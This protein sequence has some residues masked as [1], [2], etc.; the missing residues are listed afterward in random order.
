ML[1]DVRIKVKDGGLGL[2]S[3]AGAGVHLK[4]GVA[5]LAAP[6]VIAIT[7]KDDAIEKLGNGPLLD[8]VLD[9]LQ[10]GSKLIYCIPTA[11]TIVGTKTAVAKTGTG[12]A[13]YAVNGDPNNTYDIVIQIVQG[14]ALNQATYIYSLNGGETYTKEKSVPSDGNVVL[15]GT[16]LSVKFTAAATPADSFKAGDS[17]VFQTTAPKMSNQEVMDAVEVAKKSTYEFEFIHIAGGSDVTLWAALASE[18]ENMFNNLFTPIYFVCEARDINQGEDI[19]TYVSSLVTDRKLISSYRLQVVATRAKISTLDGKVRESNGAAIVAGTYAK[20]KVS[21]SIGEVVSFPLNNVLQILP[22]GIEDYIQVLD[23]ANFVT[24]RQYVGL[25]GFYVTNARMFAASNSDYQ[26]AETVR[27]VNKACREVRKQ[28]LMYEHAAGDP[29]AIE[30]FKGF[31]QIPLDRMAA[32]TVKEIY[33]GEIVIPEGQDI[34]GTSSLKAVINIAP[35]PILR[36][37]NI[38]MGL[39]NPFTN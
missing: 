34:L 13:T 18:A 5:S 7:G 6:K 17:F 31:L 26:Y 20:S 37:I 24:F 14:G 15:E 19:D 39:V 35:I 25:N 2:S 21:Q 33:S 36:N 22:D 32:P 12:Q 38:E 11:G 16:G 29:E 27:T 4:I 28:A 23:E 10:S 9:S 8:A 30:N 1:N 3:D